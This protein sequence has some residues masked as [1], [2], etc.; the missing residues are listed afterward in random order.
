MMKFNAL[1]L[2]GLAMLGSAAPAHTQQ[3]PSTP[4]T[5]AAAEVMQCAQAQMVVDRLLS[6]ANTRLEAARQ[7]NSAG[8][9]RAAV[10][11]LQATLRDVRAQL[12]PCANVQPATD[13]HAG[14]TMPNV[15]PPPPAAPGTSSMGPATDRPAPAAVA[16]GAKAP[17]GAVD[18]HAGHVMPAAPAKP[19]PTA[20][21]A[22]GAKPPSGA[23]P[24]TPPPVDHSK[25]DMGAPAKP[26]PARGKPTP[27]SKPSG[28]PPAVD[29]SK[30][31]MSTPAKAAPA[32]SAKPEAQVTDPVCGLKI[33]PATAPSTTHQ[34]QMHYFCSEQHQQLFQ[35]NPAKFLPKQR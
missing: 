28:S 13:A 26:A 21:P 15:Q 12:A 20:K 6:R 11:E 34:G 32:Q 14:H 30:M 24:S 25:M 4:P 3:T 9:M 22:P 16:P 27:G 17:A 5:T 7:T 29:H 2:A 8:D 23:K 1:L 35:K 18:P 33:D 31:D 19:R 10:D